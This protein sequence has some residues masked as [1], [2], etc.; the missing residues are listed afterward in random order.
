MGKN[1]NIRVLGLRQFDIDDR[2]FYVNTLSAHL[3]PSH[4]HINTPH[5]H[6]FFAA[7][8]FTAG[9]GI[10]EIDFNT[11]SVKP[12]AMFLLSPG[13][14]HNWKLSDDCEGMIFFH[15]QDF[16]D[17]HYIHDTVKDYPF[18]SSTQNQVAVY[19]DEPAFGEIENLFRKIHQVFS[20]D[21][22]KRKQMVLS[23]VTQIYINVE[24]YV[25]AG[26]PV[27][28]NEHSSYYLKFLRF[29]NLVEENF[30][31]ERSANKYAEWM[32]ITP[33]HLNRINKLI[34]NKTSSEIIAD[35]IVLEAKRMLIYARNNF[36]EVGDALGFNDYAHFSKLFKNKTGLTPTDFSKKYS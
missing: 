31:K 8:L 30:R 26:S 7:I 1:S 17:T 5:K 36:N 33:K 29:E 22:V 25:S 11:Y 13:Q 35:R 3:L 15:S 23:L 16:Y 2:Q 19:L 20:D 6:D 21:Q 28:V 18:F 24:N 14:T 12:G 9:S 32:H 27:S 10:H 34:V 4:L